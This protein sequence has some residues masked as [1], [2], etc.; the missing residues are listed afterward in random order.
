[1]QAKQNSK[2]SAWLKRLL[3]ILEECLKLPYVIKTGWWPGNEATVGKKI[4]DT[5][6]SKV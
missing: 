3:F 1:M 2:Q 5:V 6:V 4:T